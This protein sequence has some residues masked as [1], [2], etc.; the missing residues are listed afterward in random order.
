MAEYI[1]REALLKEL[2]EEIDF[3]T[4]MYTEEQKQVVQCWFEMCG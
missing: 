3:E 1:E 2:Q 4:T